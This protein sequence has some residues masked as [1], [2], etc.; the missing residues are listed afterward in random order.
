LALCNELNNLLPPERTRE[1][2]CF[3]AGFDLAGFEE[4]QNGK[5]SVAYRVSNGRKLWGCMKRYPISD[6][7]PLSEKPLLTGGDPTLCNKAIE[8]HECSRMT[9]DDDLKTQCEYMRSLITTV[10]QSNS[11]V[12]VPSISDTRIEDYETV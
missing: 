11:P 8:I 7:K 3:S 4:N 12:T 1:I 2:Q 5:G 10:L 6:S 9:K